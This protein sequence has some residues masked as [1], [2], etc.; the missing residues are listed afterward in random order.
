MGNYVEINASVWEEIKKTASSFNIEKSGR[1]QVEKQTGK[2]RGVR[3][4]RLRG[5]R[6]CVECKRD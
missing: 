5:M 2:K 3:K 4:R 1:I 6:S